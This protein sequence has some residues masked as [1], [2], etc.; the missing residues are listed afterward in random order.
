M[1]VAPIVKTG[2]AVHACLDGNIECK[3]AKLLLVPEW[4][5]NRWLDAT[6]RISHWYVNVS[7]S[8]KPFRNVRRTWSSINKH[9][10]VSTLIKADWPKWMCGKSGS[11]KQWLCVSDCRPLIFQD[12]GSGDN[13]KSS[14][15][16][17]LYECY[18]IIYIIYALFVITNYS[19]YNIY[20]YRICF[21]L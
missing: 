14:S 2:S 6:F 20:Q 16:S 17:L 8:I 18:I 13:Y 3:K 5:D 7:L 12:L 9:L 1:N 11:R 15:R 21:C 19:N 4:R 10:V